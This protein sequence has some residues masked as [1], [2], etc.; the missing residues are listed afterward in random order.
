MTNAATP[1]SLPRESFTRTE[2]FTVALFSFFAALVVLPGIV[3][4]AIAVFSTAS[5]DL[6]PKP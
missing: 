2:K 3:F 1:E 6:G 5:I 4:S